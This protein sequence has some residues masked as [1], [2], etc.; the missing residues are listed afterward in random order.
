MKEIVFQ[1]LQ[2]H[3]SVF[4]DVCSQLE[5]IQEME[6]NF[7]EVARFDKEIERLHKEQEIGRAHV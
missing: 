3:V 6:V 2:V 4:L 7:E 1:T 5:H